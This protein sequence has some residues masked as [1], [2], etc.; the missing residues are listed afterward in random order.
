M[1]RRQQ[2]IRIDLLEKS[3][4]KVKNEK[5]SEIKVI[6]RKAEGESLEQKKFYESN[7]QKTIESS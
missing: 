5:D 3:L 1:E 7:I 4:S 2:N 6:R